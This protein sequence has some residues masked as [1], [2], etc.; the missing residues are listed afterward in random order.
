M[1]LRKREWLV[2]GIN[3]PPESCGKIFIER[4]SNQR[5][6]LH[7]SYDNILLLDDFNMAPDI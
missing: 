4:F 3:K 5:N 7:R 6:D 1:N 2:I